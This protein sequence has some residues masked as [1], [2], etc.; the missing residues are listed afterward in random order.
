M[1]IKT[2]KRA[3]DIGQLITNPDP[4]VTRDSFNAC[5]CRPFLV[6]FSSKNFLMCPFLTS[7]SI[8]GRVEAIPNKS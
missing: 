1:S 7:K 6:I 8:Y 4:T 2:Y 5:I 3:T